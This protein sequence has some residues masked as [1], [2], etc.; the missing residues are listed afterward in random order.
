MRK[1]PRADEIEIRRLIGGSRRMQRLNTSQKSNLVKVL[2]ARYDA[3]C[4]AIRSLLNLIELERGHNLAAVDGDAPPE[5]SVSWAELRAAMN[6]E[7]V[8]AKR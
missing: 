1:L 4:W 2:S 3:P 7:K 8:W 6:G 5:P